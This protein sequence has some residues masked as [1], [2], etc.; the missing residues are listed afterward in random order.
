MF[1][2]DLATSPWRA[3]HGEHACDLN[4]DLPA[5]AVEQFIQAEQPRERL[6]RFRYLSQNRRRI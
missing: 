5:S 3:P 1:E 2:N 6:K 4:S